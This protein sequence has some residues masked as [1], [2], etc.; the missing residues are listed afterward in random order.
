MLCRG[1]GRCA[2]PLR[3]PMLFVRIVLGLAL[4]YVALVILAWR[5]QDRLAFSAPRAPLPDPKR[6][7]VANGERGELVSGDGTHLVGWY[8]EAMA[9]EAAGGRGPSLP[10]SPAPSRALLWFY[11]NGET[12]AA[13]WPIVRDFQPPGTAVL[14]VDYPGYGGSE[15]RATEAGM[16]GAADAA[17]AALVARP[18]IDPGRIYV[19]RPSPRPPPP[20]RGGRRRLCGGG[21]AARHRSRADLCLRPLARHRRRDLGGRASSRGRRDPRIPLH[22]C[23]RDG[24]PALCPA[25]ALYP[26]SV[27]RQPRSHAADP[28]PGPGVSR[29]RRPRLS[30]D[31]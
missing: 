16:Y 4:A 27:A 18:G 21:R 14:V 15:G 3:L 25:A 22:Q 12:I 29:R 10:R 8:L 26:A 28:L 19:Y 2:P 1:A 9:R 13:I 30:S 17:Y 23:G 11:G 24:A 31:R 7:G 20:A 5:F 6:V